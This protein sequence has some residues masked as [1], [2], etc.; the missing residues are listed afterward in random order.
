MG[1]AATMDATDEGGDGG[2]MTAPAATSVVP[3]ARAAIIARRESMQLLPRA[4]ARV[5]MELR[6]HGYESGYLL[7]ARGNF[8]PRDAF[9]CR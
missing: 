6:L 4:S 5:A 7:P 1:S 2:D 9:H 3:T 8:L